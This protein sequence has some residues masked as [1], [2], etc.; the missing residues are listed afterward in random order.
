MS[1]TMISSCEYGSLFDHQYEL[2]SLIGNYHEI[3]D[4]L[5]EGIDEIRNSKNSCEHVNFACEMQRFSN[6]VKWKL[7]LSAEL[8]FRVQC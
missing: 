2:H 5:W 8:T 4:S 3:Q 1:V 6:L 7:G